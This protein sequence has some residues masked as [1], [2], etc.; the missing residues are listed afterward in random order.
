MY[1]N[2]NPYSGSTLTH[3]GVKGMKWGVRRRAKK[4]AKEYARAKMFYGEGAGNRR[5]LIK[6]KVEE[7]SKDPFYKQEF[8][9]ALKKQDMAKHADA[10][11]RERARKTAASTTAK[12]A[13][14]LINSATGNIGKASAA[15]AALYTIGHYTGIN[16]QI[17][18]FAQARMSDVQDYIKGR[19]ASQ[20]ILDQMF[21]N[22]RNR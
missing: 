3:Y 16:K 19:K 21:R 13:R 5:K 17:S 20:D 22:A 8:D 11:K 2:Y 6:A 14:G 10:A 18:Q 9:K 12:T 4:D 15:A 7:R 1:T